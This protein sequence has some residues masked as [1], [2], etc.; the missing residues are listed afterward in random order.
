MTINLCALLFAAIHGME[1][2]LL[3]LLLPNNNQLFPFLQSPSPAAT[4]LVPRAMWRL[5]C[6]E[7]T[8]INVKLVPVER[9]WPGWGRANNEGGGR[10]TLTFNIVLG[11]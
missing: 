5:W 9:G 7:V 11:K 2:C 3:T 4:M 1:M 6:V 8:K 10:G